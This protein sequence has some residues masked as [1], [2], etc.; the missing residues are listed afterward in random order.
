MDPI[1]VW[2]DPDAP[3]VDPN[4]PGNPDPDDPIPTWN[5]DMDTDELKAYR[6]RFAAWRTRH[7]EFQ[8]DPGF[9]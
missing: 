2:R 1:V 8:P 7:P 9:S 3:R 5:W 6:T 4:Y